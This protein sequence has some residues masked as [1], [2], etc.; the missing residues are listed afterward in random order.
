MTTA[1]TIDTSSP[2]RA[3]P[4]QGLQPFTEADTRYFFG[5]KRDQSIIISNL[6]AASLTILYGASG[7]GKSSILLAGVV[8]QLKKIPELEVAEDGS[9]ESSAQGSASTDSVPR[10]EKRPP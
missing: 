9:E 5:R 8:P 3:S 2:P 10:L 4:Y 6:Y 7:V 1:P